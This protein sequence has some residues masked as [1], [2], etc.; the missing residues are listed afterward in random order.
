MD[1][2]QP[3]T[4]SGYPV[5]AYRPPGN[6]FQ[7]LPAPEQHPPN[8]IKPPS[9]LPQMPGLPAPTPPPTEPFTPS[10]LFSVPVGPTY[11][12]RLE[13]AMLALRTNF[14]WEGYQVVRK[15]YSASRYDPSLTIRPDSI[16]FNN[17][18]LKE[19]QAVTH[20][21]LHFHPEIKVLVITPCSPATK[22]ALRWCVIRDDESR[23]ARQIT[24]P[25][26]VK[27]LYPV[28]GWDIS[29]RYRI[30]GFHVD[31]DGED[32]FMFDLPLAKP[33][34]PQKRDPVTGKV[35]PTEQP[36]G[37]LDNEESFGSSVEDHRAAMHIS[38][39]NGFTT[40]N[41]QAAATGRTAW[42]GEHAT[43]DA[44]NAHEGMVGG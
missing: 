2:S 14:T 17:A 12:E 43:T 10:P 32:G 31:A 6:G 22:D 3:W 27:K 16:F 26:L 9:N 37:P 25:D 20:V 8:N 29:F 35:I 42:T 44:Q 7:P 28:L 36:P 4:G 40:M 41:E 1:Y 23:G 5:P 21:L 30:Q 18:C 38:L 24:C 15:E 19:Y 39:K 11:A 13:A 33:F 34:V